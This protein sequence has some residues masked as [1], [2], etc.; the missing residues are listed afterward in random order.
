ME[1]NKHLCQIGGKVNLENLKSK[2][3]LSLCED[4]Q[5]TCPQAIILSSD[6]LLESLNIHQMQILVKF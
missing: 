3:K 4:S 2:M 1:N 6:K 5:H